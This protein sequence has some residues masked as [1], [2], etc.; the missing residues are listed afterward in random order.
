MHA[1]HTQEPWTT[2]S[3]V[4]NRTV[5]WP[6]P[7]WSYDQRFDA[8]HQDNKNGAPL[9]QTMHALTTDALK[10]W[11]CREAVCTSVPDDTFLTVT[12]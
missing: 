1:T 5:Q 9:A 11:E 7:Q 12:Y 3:Y 8:I 6:P 2:H 10:L 4:S